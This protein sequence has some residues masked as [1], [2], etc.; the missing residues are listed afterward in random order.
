MKAKWIILIVLSVLLI[1]YLIGRSK[2]KKRGCAMSAFS[3]TI[4]G[5]PVCSKDVSADLRRQYEN[6]CEELYNT[7]AEVQ[8][9]VQQKIKAA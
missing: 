5:L 2:A 3:A 8:A 7:D 9:C 4:Y 1:I 6:E